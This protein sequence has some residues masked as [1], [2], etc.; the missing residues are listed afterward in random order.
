M[1]QRTTQLPLEKIGISPFRQVRFEATNELKIPRRY[2]L[3]NLKAVN[4]DRVNLLLS[5]EPGQE[6][7]PG[8]TLWIGG[9]NL[10]VI[11]L[12][13]STNNPGTNQNAAGSGSK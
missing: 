3:M 5:E 4:H 6:E 11:P 8:L 10:L 2:A 9:T 1:M 7:F 13:R 12:P